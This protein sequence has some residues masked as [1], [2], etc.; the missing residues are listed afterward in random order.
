MRYLVSVLPAV[1]LGQDAPSL[2]KQPGVLAW[3]LS[4]A[5]LW[6]RPAAK[7]ILATSVHL[8][9]SLSVHYI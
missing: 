5:L 3:K 9:S 4:N 2:E 6:M 1:D 8:N 7:H